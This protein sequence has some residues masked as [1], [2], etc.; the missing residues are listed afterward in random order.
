MI[1]RRSHSR[2]NLRLAALKGAPVLGWTA[3]GLLLFGCNSGR[4]AVL[5]RLPE[6]APD[7]LPGTGGAGSSP[8]VV[9]TP[10]SGQP[11]ASVVDPLDAG[12]VADGCTC[13][14]SAALR[15]LG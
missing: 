11:V 8:S 3:L 1:D 2:S 7:S 6:P 14:S 13:A 9:A 4:L 5:D 15:A 10:D 12:V